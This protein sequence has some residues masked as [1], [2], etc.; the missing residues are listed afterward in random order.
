[1]YFTASDTIRKLRLL[2]IVQPR[3]GC[4][5]RWHA[6]VQLGC[7]SILPY[8]RCRLTQ[9][10][11]NRDVNLGQTI[12]AEAKKTEV[13]EL[14]YQF[15]H[16]HFPVRQIPGRLHNLHGLFIFRTC[17]FSAPSPSVPYIHALDA[18][19]VKIFYSESPPRTGWAGANLRFSE[20]TDRR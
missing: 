6:A 11:L 20:Q 1:L 8:W 19:K 15:P 3:Y 5:H 17:T 18:R 9:T 4:S 12:E 16:L 13:S 7:I 14:Y 10:Y 2:L